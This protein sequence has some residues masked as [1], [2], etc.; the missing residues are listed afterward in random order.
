MVCVVPRVHAE[1][2]ECYD[3]ETF[4]RD[5]KIDEDPWEGLS[6]DEWLEQNPIPEKWLRRL[7][8]DELED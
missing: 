3:L 2:R 5:M 6:Y 7:E 8:R 1:A 4:Y